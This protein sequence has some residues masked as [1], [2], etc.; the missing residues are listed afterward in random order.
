MPVIVLVPAPAV[1]SLAMERCLGPEGGRDT[2]G[3]LG[4]Y[5]DP[6]LDP[7]DG[8]GRSFRT[9]RMAR[10][11]VLLLPAW[12]ARVEWPS[13][14]TGAASPRRSPLAYCCNSAGSPCCCCCCCYLARLGD[15]SEAC[16]G[17][18]ARGRA[19]PLEAEPPRRLVPSTASDIGATRD[20]VGPLALGTSS[21][22]T[23]M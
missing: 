6:G 7:D 17:L 11:L 21:V 16:I 20:H 22:C 9:R 19:R 23:L 8:L 5:P 1:A 13:P 14:R 2:V 18:T 4:G 15:G 3:A 12:V 10:L